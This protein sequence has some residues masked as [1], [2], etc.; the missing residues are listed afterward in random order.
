MAGG[1]GM[2]ER[3]MMGLMGL[4]GLVMMGVVILLSLGLRSGVVVVVRWGSSG[5]RG[6]PH[7]RRSGSGSTDAPL[8]P[9]H[10]PSHSRSHPTFRH[11]LL[12]QHR[13]KTRRTPP[14]TPT[15]PPT[16]TTCSS[17]SSLPPLR[18]GRSTTSSCCPPTSPRGGSSSHGSYGGV[19]EG[20]RRKTC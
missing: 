8:L 12:L 16:T 4:I 19:W 6:M 3:V 7:R 11:R 18:Q 1:W 9:S 13:T 15:P 17:S 14:N 2:G 5:G 20:C 10:S